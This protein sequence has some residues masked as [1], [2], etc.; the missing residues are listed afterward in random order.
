MYIMPTVQSN[1]KPSVYL[2]NNATTTLCRQSIDTAIKWMRDPVNPSSDS[3]RGVEARDMLEDGRKYIKQHC[4]AKNYSVIYTSGA[5][6]SNSLIIRSTVEAYIKC[7]KTKPHIITSST[8]HKS[9]LKTCEAL[10]EVGMLDVTYVKPGASGCIPPSL[11][12]KEITPRT[13]LITIMGANNELGCINSLKEIGIIAHE[14]KIPFHSDFVQ[15]FGKFKYNL[16]L[17]NIDAIS[18]SFHKLCGPIGCGLLVVN[19]DFIKG[20]GIDGQIGGTQQDGLRGGTQNVPAIAGALVA[21]RHTF[22]NRKEKNDK[23]YALRTYTIEELGKK[24]TITG[25]SKYMSTPTPGEISV[26]IEIV[27]LGQRDTKRTLPNTI[28]LSVVK[29]KGAPFCNVKLKKALDKF[30]VIVSI[31]SACNTSSANASHVLNA[32]NAPDVIKR[33]VLRISFCDITTKK[34]I[35]QFISAFVEGV[36]AQK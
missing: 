15:L 17:N 10:R 31:G 12:K 28:L 16:P 27:I 25:Y 23:M 29:A 9:I 3:R 4:S 14:S 33:G 13:C 5:S 21:M 7:K 32:I 22:I 18:V 34:D 1:K 30:N 6:E 8:E 35:K 2:D 19:N 11:I 24:Y 20:Y 36:N 26:P